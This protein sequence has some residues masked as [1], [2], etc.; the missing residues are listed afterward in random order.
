MRFPFPPGG[1]TVAAGIPV[2]ALEEPDN[3]FE[4]L[5]NNTDPGTLAGRTDQHDPCALLL[6]YLL[7]NKY[8]KPIFQ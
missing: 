1:V 7:Q 6:F 5:V 4:S 8:H 2:V 3:F